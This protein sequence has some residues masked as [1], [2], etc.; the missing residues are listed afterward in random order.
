[1]LFVNDDPVPLQVERGFATVER[2]WSAGDRLRLELPMPVRASTCRDEVAADRGRV[3]I[4]RGPLVYCVESA[5]NAGHAYNYL[6]RPQQAITSARVVPQTIA[7]HE[8]AAISLEAESLD[9]GKLT[10]APLVLVP[11]Y[12]WNNRGV[13]S[14]AVW[15]PDNEATLRSGALVLDDNARRFQSATATHTFDSDSGAAMVDGRLPKHSFDTSIPR[16]TSWPRRGE[17]QTLEFELARPIELR[18]VEVY[19]YGDHGGVQVPE[20]W[21]LDWQG[22][23]GD[24]QPFP[25]YNTDYYGVEPDQFNVVHPAEPLRVARLRLRVWPREDAAVGVMEFAV[26][27]E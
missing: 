23:N 9:D 27:E 17:M 3:A 21:E 25:L 1:M 26:R 7:G 18:T 4:S 8:V 13:G 20:R 16:W 12:V 14:M 24:W 11:Y 15:L 2:E 6:L 22:P 5:D 10:P 19:W